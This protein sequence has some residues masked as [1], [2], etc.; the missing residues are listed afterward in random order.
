MNTKR[1]TTATVTTN[2]GLFYL[3][4]RPPKRRIRDRAENAAKAIGTAFARFRKRKI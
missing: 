3:A 2:L 1:N 4:R